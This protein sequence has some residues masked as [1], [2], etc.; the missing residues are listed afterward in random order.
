MALRSSLARISSSHSFDSSK[1]RKRRARGSLAPGRPASASTNEAIRSWAFARYTRNSTPLRKQPA[2]ASP[3]RT[4]C[5]TTWSSAGSSGRV[6]VRP[7]F[8]PSSRGKAHSRSAPRAPMFTIAPSSSSAALT[9]RDQSRTLTTMRWARRGGTHRSSSSRRSQMNSSTG[10]GITAFA[11]AA[12]IL[13][14]ITLERDRPRTTIAL[15]AR[16]GVR[17]QQA[18]EG[19]RAVEVVA[20]QDHEVGGD[21]GGRGYRL[22]GVAHRD[23]VDV[24]APEH[25]PSELGCEIV[26]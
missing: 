20:V 23:P 22:R 3:C 19:E 9:K 21:A 14:S 12:R 7:I 24:G 18:D 1:E 5:A 17:A 2:A 15:G 6:K 25:A 4:T 8:V 16:A 10:T 11:P 26:A 13:S